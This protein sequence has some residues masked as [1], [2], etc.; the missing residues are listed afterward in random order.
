MMGICKD[1]VFAEVSDEGSDMS[2]AVEQCASL[3]VPCGAHA[4][5]SALKDI[6]IN[7]IKQPK[8]KKDGSGFKENSGSRWP[9]G[10]WLSDME[11]ADL[12]EIR[13]IIVKKSEQLHDG[14]MCV[15]FLH[16]YNKAGKSSLQESY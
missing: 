13:N 9:N 4:Q 11:I 2:A 15:E 16:L 10:D 14:I 8:P 6:Y 12:T 7:E 5:Q 3:Q 1:R